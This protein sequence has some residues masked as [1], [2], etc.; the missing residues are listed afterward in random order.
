MLIDICSCPT[1][2]TE[3]EALDAWNGVVLGVL[4]HGQATGGHLS[5]LLELAPGFAMGHAM[6]GLACLMLGRSE[7]LPPARAAGA[8]AQ[9]AL[10]LGGATERERLWCLALE[11]WLRGKPS[12]SVARMEAALRIDPAD[13][14]SMKLSHGIR[15]MLG[16]HH[17]MLRSIGRVL[18]AY[19]QTHPL[20]GYALGCHA[21]ALE[22]T[23]Q[24]RQAEITGLRGL[25]FNTDDAWGL[26]AVAH[27]YDMTHQVDR[28]I[29]LIE[30]NANAW[31]HCNN[32]RFH[33]WWHKAL[34]H[35]DKGEVDAVLDL[36][37]TKVR[38]E[39]TDDYRDFSNAS[40]LL[41]RLELEGV[42]VGARWVEL[43]ELAESRTDDG[44][45]TFADL[46][47]MLALIGD[48]RPD[49][50]ARL[51]LSVA[52]NAR[53]GDDMAAV[54]HRPGMATAQGLAAFGDAQYDAAFSHLKHAQRDFQAM[55]GSHA[56]RDIFERLTIEAGLRAGRLAESEML[57]RARSALR[58][59]AADAFTETRLAEI[60]RLNALATSSTAAE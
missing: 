38:D 13:T 55:G 9:R 26:H 24:Y 19:D 35:L 4:S 20:F 17:G 60:A 46:H 14:I 41:M 56:Q 57:I 33:V 44:S 6:K 29:D 23:G 28:G 12:Q 31:G 43:A 51:N 52:K 42:D 53:Q 36:Y 11:D 27:V 37:D 15:F 25:E 2:L 50:V 59:G 10:A 54:M 39:K 48:A 34:L 16:D 47:Y 3:R 7:M 49:A 18:G 30:S 21:F 22:E 40:S 58:D 5:N 32:F 45:L 1:S 8:E